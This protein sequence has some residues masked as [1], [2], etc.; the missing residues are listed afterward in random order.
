MYKLLILVVLAVGTSSQGDTIEE[1]SQNQSRSMTESVNFTRSINITKS[2]IEIYRN[3]F[4]I[5]RRDQIHAIEKVLLMDN[6]EK[7]HKM[8]SIMMKTIIGT[9]MKG[10][11]VLTRAGYNAGDSFPEKNDVKDSLSM[12]LEN[13]A[14]F[15]DVVVRFPFVAERELKKN[16]ENWME[17][18]IW[19]K[20]ICEK[21]EV[22]VEKHKKILQSLG[23]E[24]KIDEPDPNYENPFKVK[25]KVNQK[26][27][28][29]RQKEYEEKKR[30]EKIAAKKKKKSGPKLTKSEL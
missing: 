12:V 8:I 23:Q 11:E 4:K 25:P 6:I 15:T 1:M 22:Y 17:I 18:I 28:Q 26:T 19:A 2:P 29:E 16:K 10:K 13:T 7:Q 3:L 27:S 21:S 24:L 14:L 9:I 20:N 30:K 5:K